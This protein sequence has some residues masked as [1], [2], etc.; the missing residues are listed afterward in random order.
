MED[1]WAFNDEGVA[2]AIRA[3]PL[4]VI[5]GIGHET[6]FSIADFAADQRAPTPTAAAEL[7][8]PEQLVLLARLA[9]RQLALRR[10]VEQQINQRG[11]QVDWLARRLQHPAQYLARQR[12]VLRNLQRQLAAGLLQASARARTALAGLSRRLLL[13]RPETSLRTGQ[14]EALAA[15]LLGIRR[16]AAQRQGADLARLTASLAHLNPGAVLARG[17]CVALDERGRIVR[18]SRS[19]EPSERIAVFFERGRADAAVLAVFADGGLAPTVAAIASKT[20]P[21]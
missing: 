10:S 5:C 3:C 2:R 7:A 6:D 18:D 19:V 1:L 17:Y 11:Q 8:A 16:Q 20:G 14:V 9:A 15:R 4:P 21:E 13:A 12:E